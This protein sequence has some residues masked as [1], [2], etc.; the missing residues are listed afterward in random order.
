MANLF[1]LNPS[2]GPHL[3]KIPFPQLRTADIEHVGSLAPGN[4]FFKRIFDDFFIGL[5]GTHFPGF[6]E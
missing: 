4:E 1:T 2:S 6:F 3:D 5:E